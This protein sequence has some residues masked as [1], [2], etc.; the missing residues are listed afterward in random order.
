MNIGWH[1]KWFYIRNP[2]EAPFPKFHGECPAR[3]LSWTWETQAEEKLLIEEI[4]EIIRKRV[5]EAGL[6]G[7]TLF[8]TMRKRC[9][10]PLPERRLPMWLYSISAD[11]D[12]SLAKELPEDEVVSWLLMVL[13]GRTG[14]GHPRSRPHLPSGPEGRAKHAAQQEASREKRKKKGD[15]AAKRETR[16]RDISRRTQHGEDPD[17]IRGE[18]PSASE[19]E[20]DPSSG[21]GG[22]SEET[23]IGLL[24]TTVDIRPREASSSAPH[25]ASG[26]GASHD[27]F[28]ARKCAKVDAAEREDEEAKRARIE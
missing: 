13:K 10:M 28:D 2:P 7:A 24:A 8:F 15:K 26:S 1:G 23:W 18:Y 17:V 12:R 25:D 27:E 11:P 20:L 22:D 14:L 16:E 3:D 21:S 5:A 19:S 6:N 4:K 9:V